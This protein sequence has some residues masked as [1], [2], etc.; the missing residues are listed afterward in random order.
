MTVLH[1]YPDD[2]NRFLQSN[3][4]LERRISNKFLFTDYTCDDLAKITRLKLD[5]RKYRFPENFEFAKIFI[6]VGDNTVSLHNASLCNKLLECIIHHQE[7]RL[8][9]TI[10]CHDVSRHSM[11]KIEMVALEKAGEDFYINFIKKRSVM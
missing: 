8:E 6:Q 11:I 10:G 3:L 2:M 7:T 4:G 5:K 1:Q 9:Q